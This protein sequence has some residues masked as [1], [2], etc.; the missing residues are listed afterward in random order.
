MTRSVPLVA[1]RRA[2]TTRRSAAKS[3]ATS[4]VSHA[5]ITLRLASEAVRDGITSAVF[6]NA[7]SPPG[8]VTYDGGV[9]DE[10]LLSRVLDLAV[11]A[12]QRGDHPFGALLA[13]DGETVLEAAN[14][15]VSDGD[16][17]AH[18]EVVLVR[19][20]ER[21]GQLEA[22]PSAVVYA[23]CEPCPM[24]VGAMF[25]AGVRRVVFALSHGRL[26]ELGRPPGAVETGFAVTASEI[27]ARAR[28]PML[29]DGPHRED[30][31]ALAHVGFWY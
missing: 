31:A 14:R 16:L 26:K 12:R 27:G 29:F 20:L 10:A 9:R 24:C 2:L 17:T 13:V 7:R 23:S 22:V 11:E 28:P 21:S 8:P 3:Y 6:G 30:E 1:A 25:W 5:T 4:A 18:A 15:V 19:A